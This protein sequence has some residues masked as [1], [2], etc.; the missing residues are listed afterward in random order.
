M[1]PSFTPQSSVITAPNTCA[2]DFVAI[3]TASAPPP[4]PQFSHN[5]SFMMAQPMYTQSPPPAAYPMYIP[6]TPVSGPSSKN[7]LAMKIVCLLSVFG[8]FVAQFGWAAKVSY[9]G[10]GAMILALVVYFASGAYLLS[11]SAHCTR[12]IPAFVTGL[13]PQ[14]LAIYIAVEVGSKR[15]EAVTY[16]FGDF[17]G[18]FFVMYVCIVVLACAVCASFVAA[19][20]A[21]ILSNEPRSVQTVHKLTVWIGWVLCVLSRSYM[22]E[23]MAAQVACFVVGALVGLGGAASVLYK[24]RQHKQLLPTTGATCYTV[25]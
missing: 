20:T 3:D 21:E 13:L 16:V 17:F 1:D 6:A 11:N 14:I 22:I 15:W 23:S 12:W 5:T 2:S 10:M 9:V 18:T 8:S 25:Y 7:S 4:P 24:E 19:A